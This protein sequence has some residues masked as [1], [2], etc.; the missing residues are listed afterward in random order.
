MGAPHC[1]SGG[2]ASLH[3]NTCMA[4][5]LE[6]FCNTWPPK[7][8][9]SDGIHLHACHSVLFS[10]F[11]ARALPAATFPQRWPGPCCCCIWLAR[12]AR[13]LTLET[14]LAVF[15]CMRNLRSWSVTVS[16]SNRI[17]CRFTCITTRAAVC[18]GGVA[19]DSPTKRTP[20][21]QTSWTRP[22]CGIGGIRAHCSAYDVCRKS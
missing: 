18:I 5:V 15:P 6:H 21:F 14:S 1:G 10:L 20:R 11:F 22:V 13:Q 7:H 8:T 9:H 17:I 16:C 12:H 4:M 2:G 19:R 3:H